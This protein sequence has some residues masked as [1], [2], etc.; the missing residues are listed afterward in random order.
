M[1]SV[2]RFILP[3]LLLLLAIASS[4]T[5]A[6]T[7]PQHL[8]INTDAADFTLVAADTVQRIHIRRMDFENIGTGAKVTLQICAG[9]CGT[10]ANVRFKWDLSAA[11]T[12]T[13]GGSYT[14]ECHDVACEWVLAVGSALIARVDTGATNNVRVSLVYYLR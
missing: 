13:Q 7:V 4:P 2:R 5:A 3:F 9:T 6:Q 8:V 12:T 10:A 11:T 14:F 1:T